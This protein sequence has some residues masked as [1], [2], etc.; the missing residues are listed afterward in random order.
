MKVVF[1]L[2]SPRAQGN[3]A[4]VLDEIERSLGECDV[5]RYCLGDCK[6]NY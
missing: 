5:W 2:G 1:V 3:T 4:T 6:I